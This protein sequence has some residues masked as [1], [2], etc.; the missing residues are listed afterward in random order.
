M[1]RQYLAEGLKGAVS[2]VTDREAAKKAVLEDV[3]GGRRG[4]RIPGLLSEVDKINGNGRRYRKAVWEKNLKNGSALMNLIEKG[5]ALGLL[6]H[7]KDGL[8]TYN[9]PISHLTCAAKLNEDGTITGDIVLFD[10]PEGQRI[11]AMIEGGHNPKVSSRGF[12]TLVKGPDGI[13]EVQEDYVCE[14]WDI[15]I[16]PSFENAVLAPQRSALDTVLAKPTES[17]AVREDQSPLTPAP[18]APTPAAPVSTASAPA[19]APAP[20]QTITESMNINEVKSR[21][22][23]LKGTKPSSPSQFAESIAQVAEVHQ[24]VAA[25]VAEDAKRAYEGQRMHKE[26]EAIESAWSETQ[27]AP[28]KTAG[29][30]RESLN[31]SL[32]I[33]KNVVETALK[34][35]EALAEQL[36]AN[37]SQQSLI[38]ELTTNGTG[39]MELANKRKDQRDFTQAKYKTA[40]E[41]LLLMSNRYKED[42]T[43]VGSRV[44]QLEFAEKLSKSPELQ[45]LL[46][47]AKE[48]KDVLAIREQLEGKKPETATPAAATT[49]PSTEPQPA[50]T[51]APAAATESKPAPA[52]AAAPVTETKPTTAAANAVVDESS[53]NPRD[54]NE[55]LEITRR[56]SVASAK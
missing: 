47:E 21:I 46:K 56:L 52:A 2:F 32:Q 9:S 16:K 39:W 18:Q 26:L 54:L 42:M 8:V 33:V 17:Q 12:G 24:Q 22:S 14:G 29:K 19:V 53:R 6:E 3:S 15:V 51:A 49:T 27:A 11:K 38:E 55:S 13:D 28:A 7:P 5:D 37:A 25:Y 41:S 43:T 50:S 40:C 35:K 34:Y 10:T 20:Q 45:K 48:P 1:A 23:A 4:W 31:K 30:L 44:I 36:K